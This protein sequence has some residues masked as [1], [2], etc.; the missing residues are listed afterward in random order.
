LTH[1]IGKSGY[2]TKTIVTVQT[3]T[4]LHCST[5]E[6]QGYDEERSKG[7]GVQCPSPLWANDACCIYP[8]FPQNL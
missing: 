6:E 1:L 5:G 2:R 8:Q 3:F 7:R 4:A